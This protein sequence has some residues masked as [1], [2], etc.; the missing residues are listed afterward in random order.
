MELFSQGKMYTEVLNII[1]DDL[2]NA[3]SAIP[4][5]QKRG[6]PDHPRQKVADEWAALTL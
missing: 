5:V 4:K 2:E 1:I 6:I 3:T